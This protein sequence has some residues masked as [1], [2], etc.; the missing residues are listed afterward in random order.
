MA[1]RL[2][3]IHTND[4]H[5]RLE[6][7]P[8][9]ATAIR[10]LR[11][12]MPDDRVLL[13]DCGDHMDRMR[14]ETEG[15]MGRVNVALLNRLGV[16]AVVPGNNEGLTFL[17][18]AL[19]EL[20][21]R[22]ARFRVL[23]CNLVCRKTGAPPPWMEPAVVVRKAGR[24]IALIGV[25]AAFSDFYE[26]LGWDAL[27][28]IDSVRSTVARLRANCDAVIV[29]SHLGF[30]LDRR[31]AS[32]VDG[33]DVVLGSHTHHLLER[34]VRFGGAWIGAAGKF[35][36]HVGWMLLTLGGENGGVELED[37]G[38]VESNRYPPEPWVERELG[39][40][41]EEAR[42]ALSG[43]AVELP[44]ALPVRWDAESPLG[45][46]AADALRRWTGADIGLVN[47]GQ[48]LDGL[49]AGPVTFGDIHRVCPSPVNPCRMRIGGNDLLRALEESLL[50]EFY[51]MPVRGFGFR[52]D[53]LGVLCVSS[54]VRIEYDDAGSPYGKIRRVAVDGR[55]LEPERMYDVGTIDMFTFSVGYMSLARG[56]DKRFYLPEFL[57][58]VLLA[59]L[60]EEKG[61]EECRISRW[62]KRESEMKED[63]G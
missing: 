50:P 5:S 44:A 55:P 10:S 19:A 16:E 23:C 8:H 26:P 4:L 38:C 41:R 39:V 42:R 45:N 20:Y 11:E 56:E 46:L 33:V 48:L 47:A 32:E 53:R 62:R 52:G 27:D 14:P 49:P 22:Q 30:P 18:E 29:L 60:K 25:T 12:G 3:V 57:R 63:D 35:G 6:A 40:F 31:L 43:V 36:E 1:D 13:V 61:M 17:P 51:H 15:T 7:V 2:L 28:P 59:G 34:P 24:S 21:G 54:N 37:G 58:D 9:L